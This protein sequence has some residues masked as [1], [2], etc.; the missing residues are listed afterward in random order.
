MKRG[1][2]RW[3]R[4]G[5]RIRGSS[6]RPD[7]RHLRRVIAQI[8]LLQID[9]V[10]VLVRSHYLPLFSR[11]GGYAPEILD[12]SWLGAPAN[13]ELFEYWGHMASLMPLEMHP[14]L[15]WRMAEAAANHRD[16][17][18]RVA[19]LEQRRP[20]FMR[21]ALKEIAQ[22][23]ALSARELTGA[24]AS[25]GGWWGWS[26]GKRALEALFAAGRVAA[27]GRRGFERLY[28]LPERVIPAR[29]LA[30]PT[31][32]PEDAQ[33]S[34][35]RIAARALGVGTE[36]D[37]CD[38]FRIRI[39]AGRLR[40]RELVE[41]GELIPVAVEGWPQPAFIARDAR[42]PRTVDARAVLS[43][44][45]SLIW[46][47]ARTERIFGFRYRIEIYTPS[48][49]RKYGYY[50]LPF[51]L[52][53]RLVGR[54]DLKS[55]RATGTL[56]VRGAH[57]EPGVRL[58]DVA[59]PLMHEITTIASWLGLERIEVTRRGNLARMLRA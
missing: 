38:Y 53:D 55:D 34:L 56:L 35:M 6:A 7:V 24:G 8:G 30:M 23:G 47:R 37:L 17:D 12:A 49:N 48:A 36:K 3:R 59:E 22:R 26:D 33:R 57:S 18:T 42:L 21:A 20:G 54:V 58:S 29:V 9:S 15:R 31:P 44:F 45:D 19:S 10:N 27:A 11:L 41:A 50:V 43:P 51:L 16:S 2:L 5:S 28:D 52:G 25:A 39:G 46:E 13:R 4:R 14:L 32:A 1:E 40:I